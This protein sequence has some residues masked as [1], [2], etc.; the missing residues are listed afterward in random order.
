MSP[1][2]H[3]CFLSIA[4]TWFFFYIFVSLCNL[5]PALNRA[6][7]P[8]YS[9]G[10]SSNANRNLI[11]GNGMV[12]SNS[13]TNNHPSSSSS[14]EFYSQSQTP[15]ASLNHFGIF[16]L[17]PIFLLTT[18]PLYFHSLTFTRILLTLFLHHLLLF[19]YLSY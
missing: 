11:I 7:G 9:N 12:H 8:S 16:F 14:S 18:Q 6:A 5:F 2:I 3:I 13:T 17:S 19:P 1:Y 10:G 4:L 15:F